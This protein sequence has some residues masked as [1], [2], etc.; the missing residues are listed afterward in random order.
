MGRIEDGNLTKLNNM[1][2]WIK[3]YNIVTDAPTLSYLQ[4]MRN[5]RAH[6]RAPSLEER[7]RLLE[8]APW[9]AN[10]YLTYILLFEKK[11]EELY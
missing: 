8:S 10:L 5:E 4:T 9:G 2:Q 3:K 11:R 7:K 6:G 1:I